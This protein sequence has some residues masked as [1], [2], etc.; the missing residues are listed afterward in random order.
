MKTLIV[1]TLLKAQVVFPKLNLESLEIG[2]RQPSGAPDVLW[3]WRISTN[4]GAFDVSNNHR[5]IRIALEA[6]SGM[7]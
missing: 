2:A 5:L 3:A 4:L 7:K 1:E 6:E